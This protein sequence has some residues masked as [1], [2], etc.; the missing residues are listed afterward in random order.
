MTPAVTGTRRGRPFV[1][2]IVAGVIASMLLAACAPQAVRDQSAGSGAPAARA[3]KPRIDP[4]VAARILAID[5]ERVTERDVRETLVHGPTPRIVL[6]HGGV[7]PVHLVMVSFGRFL[8]GMGYPEAKVRQPD[9][10]FSI[11]P[12]TDSTKVAGML[13]WWYE[14]EGARPMLV[15]HSQG[16]MLAVKLLHELNGEYGSDIAVWNPQSD[17]AEP[18]T[19]IV[20]PLTG[21]TRPVVGLSVASTRVVGA[22]G[23]SALLPN[24]WRVISRL[25]DIPDT[26]AEF[27]GYIIEVDLFAW[28]FSPAGVDQYTARGQAKVRNVVLP[29]WYMHVTLPVTHHLADDPAMRDWLYAYSPGSEERRPPPFD[30]AADSALW[31]ADVWYTIRKHWVLEAQRAVRA[32]AE[33][34]AGR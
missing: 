13:A 27:V 26:T 23:P 32:Q 4:A 33:R 14:H 9:R 18:R 34:G 5:P 28:T 22:G 6:L 20:D 2:A 31:A 24:Q 29:G 25:R 7:F 3:A 19:T 10:S 11:S 21:A 15:G 16:G 1:A 8:M 12:Y 30:S 17:E